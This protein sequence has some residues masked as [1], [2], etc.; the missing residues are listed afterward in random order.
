[1]SNNENEI[2]KILK[3]KYLIGPRLDMDKNNLIGLNSFSGDKNSAF[4]ELYGKEK[5]FKLLICKP[6]GSLFI[7]NYLGKNYLLF[8]LVEKEGVKGGFITNNGWTLEQF[9]KIFED[10]ESKEIVELF[11]L[12]KKYVINHFNELNQ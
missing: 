4:Y 9:N 8:L 1:M 3:S 5:I 6:S 12:S 2:Y 7:N 11:E 10:L